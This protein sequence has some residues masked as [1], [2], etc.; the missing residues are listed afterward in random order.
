MSELRNMAEADSPL[1]PYY[2]PAQKLA[3]EVCANLDPEAFKE[4]IKKCSDD[5]YEKL[6]DTTQNYLRENAESNLQSETWRFV[7]DAVQALLTGE[8]WALRRYA[9]GDRYDAIKVRAAIAKHVPAELQNARIADL[10][11]E[12]ERLRSDLRIYRDR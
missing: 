11:K 7:D 8:E 9:V 12:V 5:L 3:E 10:E 4:I 1:G 2:H 6:L